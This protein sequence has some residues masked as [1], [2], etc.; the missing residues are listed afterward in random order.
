AIDL[1]LERSRSASKDRERGQTTLFSLLEAQPAPGGGAGERLEGYPACDPWD[2]RETL[3]R[4]KQSLGFYL[5]GH[6]LARYGKELRRFELA[7][8]VELPGMQQWAKVRLAGMVE[9][10]RE[11]IFRTGRVAFFELEDEVGRVDVK[12]LEKK[13]EACWSLLGSKEPVLVEGKVSF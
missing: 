10:L 3:V 6:P 8:T 1:A 7:S 5:S 9:N 11:R 2:V 13:V 4:E 12:V